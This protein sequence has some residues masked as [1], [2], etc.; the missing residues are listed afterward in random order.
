MLAAIA[1]KPAR[2]QLTVHRIFEE[3]RDAATRAVR[4]GGTVRPA[5]EQGARTLCGRGL[6][7]AQLCRSVPIRREP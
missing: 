4:C 5:M 3:L 1:A 7:P 2:Q 6:R